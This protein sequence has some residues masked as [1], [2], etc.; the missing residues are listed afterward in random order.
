MTMGIVVDDTV[1]FLSKYLRGRREK[2]LDAAGSV[3]YAFSSVGRALVVT[4]AVLTA[5][6]LI[7]AQSTFKQNADLGLLAAVTIFFA[8]VADFFLL[9]PLLLRLDR[10]GKDPEADP[11]LEAT[12]AALP[13]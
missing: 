7:L 9:P 3:R 13:Q 12:A 8:L 2:G 11:A 1:H 10:R 4:S 6:F 5:G